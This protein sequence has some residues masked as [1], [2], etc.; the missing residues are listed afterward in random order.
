MKKTRILP[1]HSGGMGQITSLHVVQTAQDWWS[2]VGNF[3]QF[4]L[5][6]EVIPLAKLDV[7]FL[8]SYP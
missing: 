7:A 3:F 2:T 6:M 8:W 4:V 1:A 5:D